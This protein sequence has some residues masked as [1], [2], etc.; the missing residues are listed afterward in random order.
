MS[1]TPPHLPILS[2]LIFSLDK[3]SLTAFTSYV[4]ASKSQISLERSAVCQT[5]PSVNPLFLK[6]YMSKHV[7]F[8]LNLSLLHLLSSV[9]QM[10]APR[11]S[12]PPNLGSTKLNLITRSPLGSKNDEARGL[13]RKQRIH[14]SKK[15]KILGNNFN[16]RSARH[17]KTTKCCW[18]QL[19]K[20]KINVET[21]FTDWK[22][23]RC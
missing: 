18:E 3:N 5:T 19:K 13:R 20:I 4:L 23:Q 12:L 11:S 6:F 17:T 7:I 8:S 21:M 16:K 1:A 14:R 10:V 22:T 15:N 9:Y 2:L